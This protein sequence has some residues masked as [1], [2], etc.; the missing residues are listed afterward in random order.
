MYIFTACWEALLP[1]PQMSPL[2]A[3]NNKETQEDEKMDKEKKHHFHIELTEQQYE[4]L[5]KI[6]RPAV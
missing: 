4:L 1:N 2:W 3:G 6:A 5:K